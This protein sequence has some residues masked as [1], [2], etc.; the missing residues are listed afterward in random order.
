MK[1][2]LDE[3]IDRRLAK[4]LQLFSVRTVHDTG[5]VTIENG[6]LLALAQDEF[7]VFVTVDRNL[8]FQQ[9]VP[10]FNLA[11]VVLSARSN[12]LADLLPLVPRLLQS[13]PIRAQ[14][15]VTSVGL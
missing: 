7:D 10:K 11:V 2:L 1:V 4:H 14:G 15:V 12:R 9:N 3:Y 13:H 8:A 6:K 5:W